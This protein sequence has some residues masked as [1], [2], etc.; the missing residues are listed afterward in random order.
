MMEAPNRALGIRVVHVTP[1]VGRHSFGP[2]AVALSLA[3][4]QAERGLDATV[5]CADDNADV[6]WA[7]RSSGL[8]PDAIRAFG[9]LGPRRLAFSP[10]MERAATMRS[11]SDITVAHQHGIWS[12]TS[13]VVALLRERLRI[14]TIIA[15]H[16]SLQPWVQRRS[17]LKKWAAA[18]AYEK[19]NLRDASC[20]HACALPEVADY[21]DFGLKKPIAVIPNGISESWLRSVGDG[22]RFRKEHGLSDDRR[23]LLFLS[24]ITPKK[25]L[26]VLLQAMSSHR[27]RLADWLLLIAGVDERGH[28][29]EVQGY[30]DDVGLGAQVRFVGPLFDQAKRDAF[31]AADL[32]VLPTHSEGAPLAV[33]ESLAVS[34]P[35]LTTKAAPWD[36]IEQRVCGWR[37]DAT[38]EEVGRGLLEAVSRTSEE[39]RAM[40]RRGR[41]MVE[42]SYLWSRPAK[43][44][45]QLYEWLRGVRE[46][47][48][49]VVVD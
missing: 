1:W 39:L 10:A 7:S 29:A 22:A 28:Q 46:R 18:N 38:P 43:M 35:V 24:R 33:L 25:G 44:T 27:S 34:V 4:A 37:V 3:L 47:P 42:E 13:R 14:P 11:A 41:E 5:W 32:F 19:R 21:R 2:G 15:A 26:P 8:A 12:A 31:A 45:V 49:F 40:G 48:D 20:L 23:V 9:N 16:G 36:E 30:V 17:R 6:A